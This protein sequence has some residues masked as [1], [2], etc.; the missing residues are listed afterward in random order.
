MV[1]FEDPGPRPHYPIYLFIVQRRLKLSPPDSGKTP[2]ATESSHT[3]V[4]FVQILLSDNKIYSGRPQMR[5]NV[6]YAVNITVTT[7]SPLS[8]IYGKDV[9]DDRPLSHQRD[10]GPQS[11]VSRSSEV[12]GCEC[13]MLR[14][15]T[16][17]NMIIP[18]H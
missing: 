14:P 18:S 10:R 4:A 7:C 6:L 11:R 9:I 1:A 3:D 13:S 2:N 5:Y 16:G 12:P 15:G 8:S 17:W